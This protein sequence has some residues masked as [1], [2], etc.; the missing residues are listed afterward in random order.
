MGA[1]VRRRRGLMALCPERYCPNGV[2]EIDARQLRAE[3]AQAVL[4]DLDNTLVGWHRRDVPAAVVEWIESLKAAGLK[5]CLVSNTRYGERLRTLASELE[6]PFVR[7][8]WKPR[9]RGFREALAELG[10][11][12]EDA[13]M[14]GD[15]VFTDV[16]GGNRMGMRTI[17]V[18]P[19]YRREFLGT[20]IS[21][22]VERVLLAYF[23]AAG[24]L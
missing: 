5:L 20:K 8:A 1:R 17:L 22:A 14:V 3:G 4:L 12:P 24:R 10:V 9:R 18:R 11:A 2:T 15:Q 6:I 21:R 13:V 16:W 7:R 23:R 19:M